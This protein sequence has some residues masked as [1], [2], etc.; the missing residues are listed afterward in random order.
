M[1]WIQLILTRLVLIGIGTISVV[2][3]DFSSNTLSYCRELPTLTSDL[4]SPAQTAKVDDYMLKVQRLLPVFF[5]STGL[6]QLD[7]IIR[8]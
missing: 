1:F 3:S 6:D 7:S 4:R 5:L 8:D 2:D